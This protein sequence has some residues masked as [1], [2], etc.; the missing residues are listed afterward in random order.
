MIKMYDSGL[1]RFNHQLAACEGYPDML[2]CTDAICACN[3]A[4]KVR[5]RGW[6]SSTATLVRLQEHGR[7]CSENPAARST[8]HRGASLPLEVH[9][10]RK[11]G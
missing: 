3:A 8:S 6:N 1:S 4:A 10:C 9:C 11:A 2:G 7:R 5:M